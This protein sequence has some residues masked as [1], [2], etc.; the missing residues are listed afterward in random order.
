[1]ASQGSVLKTLGGVQKAKPN[2]TGAKSVAEALG[3][4]KAIVNIAGCPPN[5][6]NFIGTVV[7]YITKGVPEL[8]ANLRPKLFFGE[9]VHDHCPR[10][11][12]FEEEKFA[13]SFD[14]E[15]AKKGYCLYNLGCKGPDTYNNCSTVLFNQVSFPIQAGHPCI[16]CSEPDFWDKMSPFYESA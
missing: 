1:L 12:Y 15:T 14:D 4:T 6:F 10:L 3:T 7:H 8:D 2:P 13:K 11:K 5:P 9:T 16:G